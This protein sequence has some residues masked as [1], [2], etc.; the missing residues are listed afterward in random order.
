MRKTTVT[1]V[2]ISQV[3]EQLGFSDDMAQHVDAVGFSNVS[4]G[5]AFATLI[6]NRYAWECILDGVRDYHI[7]LNRETPEDEVEELR[8]KYWDAV[9]LDNYVNVEC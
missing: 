1:F 4:Y 5:D 9:G 8:A 6:G 7:L 2:D 3:Y